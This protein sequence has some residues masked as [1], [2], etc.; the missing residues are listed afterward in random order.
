MREA[1]NPLVPAAYDVTWT[2]IT[3][4]ILLLLVIA[5]ISLARVA[6]S[7]TPTQALTWVLVAILLPVL[8]PFAWLAIGR[9]S[10]AAAGPPRKHGR[11]APAQR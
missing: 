10:V 5:L 8:G 1:V 3:G 6:K 2:A 7:L 9:R 4:A 11:Q